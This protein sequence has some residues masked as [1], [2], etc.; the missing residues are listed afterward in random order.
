MRPGRIHLVCDVADVAAAVPLV[1]RPAEGGFDETPMVG[2]ELFRAGHQ[3]ACRIARPI[4]AIQQIL[5]EMAEGAGVGDDAGWPP[6]LE[7]L[8]V[9]FKDFRREPKAVEGPDVGD[10]AID[11]DT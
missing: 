9:T 1:H 6:S 7:F 8:V 10:E 5:G 3:T 2:D 11:A 4:P